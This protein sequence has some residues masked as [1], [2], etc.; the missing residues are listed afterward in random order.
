MVPADGGQNDRR[1]S[2]FLADHDTLVELKLKTSEIAGIMNDHEM[3]V[4]HLESVRV[5][6]LEDQQNEWKG[7]LKTWA[8]IILIVEIAMNLI[9]YFM[10]AR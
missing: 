9:T 10:G 6:R 3:R 5:R 4:R 8:I 1:K 7:A 2:D